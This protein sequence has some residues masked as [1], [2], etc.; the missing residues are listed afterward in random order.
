MS[1]RALR[2]PAAAFALVGAALMAYLLYVR[3]TGG[4]PI[5][6]GDGCATVQRSRYA[7][8]FGVPVAALGLVGFVTVFVTSLLRGARAR[9]VQ[10]VIVL[11]A[12]GFSAYLLVV[13][14]VVIGDV[15]EWCLAGDMMTTG[16]A[17]VV[18][19]RFRSPSV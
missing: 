8:I 5:C 6:A 7:E 4:A 15:C 18:L 9:F 16:L 1:D 13:Q 19:V 12:L 17:A 11:S 3:H 2:F 10:A 14:V